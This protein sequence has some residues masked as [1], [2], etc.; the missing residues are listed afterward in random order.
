[1]V[2]RFGVA[3]DEVANFLA[4]LQQCYPVLQIIQCLSI[5]HR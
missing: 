3:F 5:S 4:I 2:S 1:M